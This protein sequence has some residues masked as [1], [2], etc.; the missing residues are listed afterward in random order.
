MILFKFAKTVPNEQPRKNRKNPPQRS[1]KAILGLEPDSNPKCDTPARQKYHTLVFARK[2]VKDV[3]F[4][5][6]SA[7]QPQAVFLPS[8][9]NLVKI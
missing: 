3:I 8:K 1:R 9:S 6:T 4:K 7:L 5:T 2:N